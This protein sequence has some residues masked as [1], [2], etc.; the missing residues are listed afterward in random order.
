M[1]GQWDDEERALDRAEL[2]GDVRVDVGFFGRR[3]RVRDTEEAELLREDRI[4][5]VGMALVFV[6]GFLLGMG[7][8]GL[9]H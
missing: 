6:A 5:F 8:G 1:T 7:F 2:H 4:A 9:L 3:A